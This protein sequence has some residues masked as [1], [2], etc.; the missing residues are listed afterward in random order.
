MG[1]REP[2]LLRAQGGPYR[3]R[4]QFGDVTFQPEGDEPLT[5]EVRRASIDNDARNAALRGCSGDRSRGI[6]GERRA[7][8]H[9]QIRS[10]GRSQGALQIS[11]AQRLTKTDG[12]GLEPATT[13]TPG[14]FSGLFKA[15][16]M[17]P[18]FGTFSTT[19]AFDPPVGAVY[20]N[21]L[22]NGSPGLLVEA[23]NV[24]GDATLQPSSSLKLNN[25]VMRRVGSGR[26]EGGPLLELVIPML[27][28]RVLRRHEVIVVNWLAP[29]PHSMGASEIRDAAGGGHSRAREHQDPVRLMDK[30][31]Q[32]VVVRARFHDWAFRKKFSAVSF[33]DTAPNAHGV[34]FSFPPHTRSAASNGTSLG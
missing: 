24:L 9:D 7:Q 4:E 17:R 5:V 11:G 21:E 18:R 6:N 19:G 10:I 3:R 23:V 28:P 1:Q 13:M 16:E 30:L 12:C 29:L 15:V 27:N 34:L 8:C 20:L 14:R 22:V 33:R 32:S 2:A 25:G 26:T 31:H